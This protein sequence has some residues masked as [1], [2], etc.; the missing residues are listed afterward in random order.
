MTWETT[1]GPAAEPLTAE[2]VKTFLRISSSSTDHDALIELLITAA[3][4]WAESGTGRLC[5][6]Q[7]IKQYWDTWPTQYGPNHQALGWCLGLAPVS[8]VTSI[9][10]LDEDGATQT[11]ATTNYTADTKSKPARIVPTDDVTYPDLDDAPNA[12]I[13]TYVAGHATPAD[14][15]AK[16]KGAMLQKIAFWYENPEDIP[17]GGVGN[18]YKIRS[19]DALIFPERLHLI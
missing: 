11:W 15:P 13:V 16:V 2:E 6:S 1:T 10:Y 17:T 8:S 9:Q 5:L 14:V 18:G 19:A 3:R 12:V 7:T 4:E